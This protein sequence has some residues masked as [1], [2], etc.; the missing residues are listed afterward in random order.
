QRIYSSSTFVASAGS[1]VAVKRRNG[2]VGLSDIGRDELGKK[3][4]TGADAELAAYFLAHR[5]DFDIGRLA[6]GEIDAS[7]LIRIGNAVAIYGN[8]VMSGGYVAVQG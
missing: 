3:A 8:D 2:D 6:G 1:G 7:E 5:Q 4:G